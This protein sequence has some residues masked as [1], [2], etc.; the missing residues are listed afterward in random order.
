[1]GEEAAGG[2]FSGKKT[3]EEILSGCS[4]QVLGGK[5]KE[6][7]GRFRGVMDQKVLTRSQTETHKYVHASVP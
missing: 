3:I 2:D 7:E 1:M 5:S 6:L 4:R